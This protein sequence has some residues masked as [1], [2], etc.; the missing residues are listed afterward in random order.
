[1]IPERKAKPSFSVDAEAEK[2][3]G[4]LAPDERPNEDLTPEA[5]RVRTAYI[6]ERTRWKH[7][8]DG[9]LNTYIPD[10]K[11]DGIHGKPSVWQKIVN[12]AATKEIDPT[13]LIATLCSELGTK[14]N[15][16]SPEWF[17]GPQAWEDWTD[18]E[19]RQEHRIELALQIETQVAIS[20]IE[21]LEAI[22]CPQ[23]KARRSTLVDG[24]LSLSPLFRYCIAYDFG[25]RDIY[26][27]YRD[28]AIKQYA[29]Y[30]KWYAEHWETVL[31]PNFH[32]WAMKIYRKLMR[33]N[34]GEG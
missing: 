24:S 10:K 20:N 25:Y 19:R 22:E 7:N 28:A 14:R 13:L 12:Y 17:I 27:H 1:M 9:T 18:A 5:W 30:A 32:G 34:H 11:Y 33:V 2:G 8:M 31:P 21:Y 3:D 26:A 29:R 23:L 4:P 16:P 15:F 6:A